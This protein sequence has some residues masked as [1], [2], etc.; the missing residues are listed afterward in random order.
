MGYNPVYNAF[1]IEIMNLLCNIMDT[2]HKP[3]FSKSTR[4]NIPYIKNKTIQPIENET[5]IGITPP[6]NH[7]IAYAAFSKNISL[8]LQIF[9]DRPWKF[10]RR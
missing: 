10:S 2:T 9:W 1:K 7:S 4:D 3:A 8:A 5:M 6:P